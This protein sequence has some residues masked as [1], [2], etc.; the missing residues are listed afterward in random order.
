[1]VERKVIPITPTRAN[2][3]FPECPACIYNDEAP[4][5]CE[6][7]EDANWFDDGEG[8]GEDL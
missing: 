3:G 7:C 2:N 6:V 1:M 5:I 4:D 8:M